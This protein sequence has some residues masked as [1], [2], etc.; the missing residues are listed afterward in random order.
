MSIVRGNLCSLATASD[1]DDSGLGRWNSID[2]CNENMKLRMITA[3]HC[4]RSKQMENMVYMQ[5]LC[6]FRRI[7]QNLYPIKAF[8]IDLTQFIQTLLQQGF[9]IIICLNANENMVTGRI[10]KIF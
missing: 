4:V 5:Q 8:A 9:K 3:Y 7:G 6:Y 2:I 1:S 10:V